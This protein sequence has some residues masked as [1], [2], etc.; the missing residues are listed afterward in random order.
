MPQPESNRIEYKRELSDKLETAVV[1]F[2]NYPEGGVVYIGISDDGSVYGVE[3]VDDVQK[4]IVSRIRDNIQPSAMGLFDVIVER[5]DE[6][7]IIKVL[8]PA[9]PRSPIICGKKA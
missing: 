9:E 3:N 4:R 6:K 2:L 7:R 8:V 1:A 5:R